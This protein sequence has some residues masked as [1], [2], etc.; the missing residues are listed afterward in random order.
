[1]ITYF[2]VDC[3]ADE[4]V[5]FVQQRELNKIQNGEHIVPFCTLCRHPTTHVITWIPDC[6]QKRAA[7]QAPEGVV[8]MVIFAVCESC[9]TRPHVTEELQWK[10]VEQMH[11]NI[12]LVDSGLE[13]HH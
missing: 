1:V 4:D 5:R 3:K 10:M 12:P 8:R 7:V 11:V 6:A 13:Y 2:I 9:I